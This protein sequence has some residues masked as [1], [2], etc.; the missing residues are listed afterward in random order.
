MATYKDEILGLLAT[1]PGLT[2]REITDRL[3]GERVRHQPTSVA[4]RELARAGGLER[5]RRDDRRMGN[6]PTRAPPAAGRGLAEEFSEDE[7]KR[8]LVAWLGR[9]G[10]TSEVAWGTRPG[11]DLEATRD[12]ERWVIE[13]KGGGSYDQMRRN[14]FGAVLADTLRRMDDTKASYAIAL[15]DMTQYRRLW[16]RLPALAKKRTRVGAPFV[17][18]AETVRHE[19]EDLRKAKTSRCYVPSGGPLAWRDFLADPHKQWRTGYSAKALA[20]S[21]EAQ[22]GLPPEVTFP[23]KDGASLRCG[24]TGAARRPARMGGAAAGRVAG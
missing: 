7:V 12:D 8:A 18:G 1:T 17:D 4:C 9:P 15:P 3:R 13:A 6:Y 5:R 14:Y 22:D 24:G 20:H 10:W 11:I 23:D 16:D 2:D 19:T 21:W